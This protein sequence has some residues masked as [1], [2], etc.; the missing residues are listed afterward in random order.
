MVSSNLRVLVIGFL[1]GGFFCCFSVC[2]LNVLKYLYLTT[3]YMGYM[4]YRTR[5]NGFKQV[6]S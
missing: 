6:E 5:G 1:G 3:V 2:V 4:V